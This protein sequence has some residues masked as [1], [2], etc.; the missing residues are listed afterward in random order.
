M[1]RHVVCAGS[2]DT[3]EGTVPAPRKSQRQHPSSRQHPSARQHPS[4]RQHPSARQHPCTSVSVAKRWG[5]QYDIILRKI[6]TIVDSI[7]FPRSEA[8][9]V[10]SVHAE[11]SVPKSYPASIAEP[12]I[13]HTTEECRR[14]A[15][16]RRKRTG[17]Q[18]FAMTDAQ[19]LQHE[20][21]FK[22]RYFPARSTAT[23]TSSKSKQQTAPK[24]KS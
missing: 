14:T 13:G 9:P 11:A 20:V 22:Y 18:F 6:A 5:T 4:P 12:I 23:S 15:C 2:W 1:R 16:S 10:Q 21:P 7:H 24:T 17:A 8:R 19:A 3:V